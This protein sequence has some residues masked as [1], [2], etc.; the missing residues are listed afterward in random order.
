MRKFLLTAFFVLLPVV[1]LPALPCSADAVDYAQQRITITLAAE[2]PNLNSMETMDQTSGFV[3]AHVM[4]GL[5]QYDAQGRLAPG[6]AERWELRADGATFWLRRDA[7]WS[8]GKSVTAHDFV[9]AWK[10]IVTPATSSHYAGILFPIKNAQRINRGEL[11]P[12]TMGVRATND[13]QLDVSFERPCPY[14]LG[15]T[16]YFIY[17]PVREDFFRSRGQRYAADADDMLYNGAFTVSRWVHGAQM[18]LTKNPHYWNRDAVSLQTID[19]A[20]MSI[21]PVSAYSLFK[22]GDIA[23]TII[24]NEGLE[25]ALR[26]GFPLVRHRTGALFY[27]EFNQEPGRAT[28]NKALR[29]AI[30][31]LLDP[32]AVAS[33][34]VGLPGLLATESLFPHWLQ[35][36]SGRF[37]DEYPPPVPARGL[38]VARQW[39]QQ[40]QREL[41]VTRIP[42]LTL[43]TR[44]DPR[45]AKEAQYLQ[46][47]LSK[48]LGIDLRIERQNTQQRYAK[49]AKGDFDIVHTG[50]GP[51]YDDPMTFAD[52]FASWNKNNRGRYR[53]AAYD[54]LVE[55]ANNSADPVQRTRAFGMMQ[56]LLIED[57]PILPLYENSKLY[58]QHPQLDGVAHTIFGVDPDYRH[59]RVLPPVSTHVSVQG[60]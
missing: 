26:N 12:E 37:R 44:E 15:L 45:A 23:L 27:F 35:G 19:I 38:Q 40:A 56:A 7:K 14:F 33:R 59:A 21:D 34:V 39:L 11:P 20:H 41:G 57:A 50:W 58:L 36:A 2:P 54:R 47:L 31:A 18:T 51:D 48:G 13:Y 49:M 52:V 17:D 9:F 25:N 43:L 55:E 6:V 22:S 32:E 16:A 1:L 42:R 53:N 3:L 28:A 24:E 8:D 5:L 4:E 60:Q 46:Q 10:R 30:Q 29:K